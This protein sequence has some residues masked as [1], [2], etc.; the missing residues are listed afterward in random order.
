MYIRFAFACPGAHGNWC[1]NVGKNQLRTGWNQSNKL[2]TVKVKDKDCPDS[3]NFWNLL[4]IIMNCNSKTQS[5]LVVGVVKNGFFLFSLE[6]NEIQHL[7][8]NVV[9][10]NK[11]RHHKP[12]DEDFKWNERI[13]SFTTKVNG[14]CSGNVSI[15][16]A[17]N[18]KY[19]PKP[20]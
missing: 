20:K 6:M 9:P 11:N 12:R 1:A 3:E 2:N 5:I 14:A 7:K 16:K 18:V 13:L 17:K 19:S 15:T 10:Q 4:W 8:L